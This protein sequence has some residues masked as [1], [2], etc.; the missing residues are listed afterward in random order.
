[1]ADGF[2]VIRD[3]D[4]EQD[5]SSLKGARE[6]R[7]KVNAFWAERGFTANARIVRHKFHKSMRGAFYEIAS[8]LRNGLPPEAFQ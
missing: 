1:M 5:E 8:D 6:L 4:L 7:D 2:V 3:A